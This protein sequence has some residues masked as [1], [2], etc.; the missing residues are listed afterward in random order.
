MRTSASLRIGE[1][2]TAA[3]CGLPAP[4]LADRRN[5]SS[6]DQDPLTHW[7]WAAYLMTTDKRGLQVYL[8]EFVFRHNRRKQPA[9]AFQTLLGLGTGRKST[10]YQHIRGAKEVS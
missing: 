6:Q 5:G 8:D 1:A 9:A 4:S 2:A 10:E 3:V 7:F